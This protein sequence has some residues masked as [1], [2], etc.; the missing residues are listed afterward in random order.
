VS[1]D[2]LVAMLEIMSPGN[3][4]S[5]RAFK[6]FLNK[7]FFLL[8]ERIHL[9]IIDPFPPGKRD[10]QGIHAAIW[11]EA[12]E[13]AF[14]L[15]PGKPLTLVSYECD[16]TTRAYVETV[17][18]GDPLPDMPLFL[19]PEENLMV[20]LEATYSAA[21]AVMPQRWRKVIE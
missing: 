10:P 21:F 19:E 9:L 20:P 11:D 16:L 5:T 2:R 7:A 14:Q 8:E 13:S 6:D 12:D 1:D 17:G 15:P 4:D 18:V 3:K